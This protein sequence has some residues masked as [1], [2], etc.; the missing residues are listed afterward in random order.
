MEEVAFFDIFDRFE[1]FECFLVQF[2][3]VFSLKCRVWVKIFFLLFI[4]TTAIWLLCDDKCV[5]SDRASFAGAPEHHIPTSGGA[6]KIGHDVKEEEKETTSELYR[7]KNQSAVNPHSANKSAS[8]R[9]QSKDLFA[10]I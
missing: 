6:K 10:S 4:A 7:S 3:L 1:L 2:I 8:T 9:F 5:F